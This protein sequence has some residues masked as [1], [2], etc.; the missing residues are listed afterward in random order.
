[1]QALPGAAG[2]GRSVGAHQSTCVLRTAVNSLFGRPGMLMALA[3][4]P[5]AGTT[6][7]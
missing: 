1:V 6:L 5:R 3:S 4:I 7:R 2:G